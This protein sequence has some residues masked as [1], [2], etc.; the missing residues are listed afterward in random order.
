MKSILSILLV[1]SLSISFGQSDCLLEQTPAK[2]LV[3]DQADILNANEESQ[4]AQKLIQF[5]KETS[6]QILVVTVQNLCGY[7]KA[8]FTY[9]LGEKWGVGQKGFDNGI[10]LMVKPHGG[11]GQR[12][13]F[14]AVGYGLEGAIPDATSKRI[15][16]AEMIP[17]FKNGDF[18]SG[19][20]QGVSVLMGLAKGEINAANY[21]ESSKPR[22][23][24]LPILFVL[25]IIFLTLFTSVQRAR[26]Y[27]LGHDVSFWAALWLL[28]ST[29]HG[30]G[31][32]FGNFNSGG[33]SFGGGFG[34]FGGGSFGGGGAGGS[35]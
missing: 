10:V 25:F 8:E 23:P 6:N 21:S 7:D 24:F 19:I 1:L 34:G 29:G 4:L 11:K 3:V 27:S 20:N 17:Y 35:W 16:E 13:T 5:N 30:R 31:G 15:V 18:N 22:I 26:K 9:A 14:I 28:S 32:G 33:G 2:T 12:H